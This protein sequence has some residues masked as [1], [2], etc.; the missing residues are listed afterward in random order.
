[1]KITSINFIDVASVPRGKTR[2]TQRS[3]DVARIIENLGRAQEGKALVITGTD[4]ARFETYAL[5]RL[6]RSQGQ[7]VSVTRGKHPTTG[8]DTIF[9]RKLTNDEWQAVLTAGAKV[10]TTAKGKGK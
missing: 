4:I 1:M 8:N 5:Q 3:Q 6:L 9:V 10:K 7:K 2:N